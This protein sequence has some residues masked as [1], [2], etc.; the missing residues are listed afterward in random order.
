MTREGRKIRQV[1]RAMVY[2]ISMLLFV[3]RLF[4]VRTSPSVIRFEKNDPRE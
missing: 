1:I 3:D 4:D 2:V